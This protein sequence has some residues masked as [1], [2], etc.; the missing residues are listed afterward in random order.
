MKSTQ[1]LWKASKGGGGRDFGNRN[2]R[3]P[4]VFSINA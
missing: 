2:I 4:G 3:E 1:D